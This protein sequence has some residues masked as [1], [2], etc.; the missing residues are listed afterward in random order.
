MKK[1]LTLI[2]VAAAALI[3]V[4]APAHAH[5]PS[6]T[7]KCQTLTVD[8]KWY[9]DDSTVTVT[10]DGTPTTISFDED[11]HA[12]FTGTK[13]WAV[14]VDNNG[15][16]YDLDQAGT[17]DPCTPS[18]STTAVPTTTTVQID[19]Q[20]T[21]TR[22]FYGY[23][24]DTKSA[25]VEFRND[26]TADD[27]VSVAG[28]E[29]RV[30]ANG[31]GRINLDRLADGRF[32]YGPIASLVDNAPVTVERRPL[33]DATGAVSIP[34]VYLDTAVESRELPQTLAFT[35]FGAAERAGLALGLL[36]IG[37]G[38]MLATQGRKAVR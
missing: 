35:G 27:R 33:I 37:A 29:V 32:L 17:F 26:G 5:T 14:T 30:P 23:D 13:T 8:L 16:G 6:I 9:E 36:V 1:I 7:S 25:W 15:E 28:R 24:C 10:I 20:V 19:I 11:Y 18:T 2:P 34:C 4:A 3:G 12:T 22:G 21:Q 38:L 31:F